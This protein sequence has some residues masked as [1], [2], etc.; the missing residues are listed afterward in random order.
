MATRNDY[1]LLEQKCLRHYQLALPY[2]QKEKGKQDYPKEIQA[3]FGFY[4]F[5]L[6]LYTE[7]SEHSDITKIITDTD[8]NAKFFDKPDSDEG[9]DAV[10]ID[11][12]NNHIQLFNFKYRFP[13]KPDSTRSKD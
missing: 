11:E 1:L 4:F 8:F 2:L 13:F 10:F 7:L 9:V 12:E 3:R 5:I 6:K